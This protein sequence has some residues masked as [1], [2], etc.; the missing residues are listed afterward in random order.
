MQSPR[1]EEHSLTSVAGTQRV[2]E[3]P[4]PAL[5]DV[6]G[7]ATSTG[8]TEGSRRGWWSGGLQHGQICSFKKPVLATAV[9]SMP[10]RGSWV[11]TGSLGKSWCLLTDSPRLIHAFLCPLVNVD[12]HCIDMG[13]GDYLF[14][15]CLL[16]LISFV[17]SKVIEG[18]DSVLCFFLCCKSLT[19]EAQWIFRWKVSAE[20]HPGCHL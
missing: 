18:G 7:S 15:C 13:T 20:D 2:R 8:K 3:R 1:D 12:V 6:V 9:D 5:Q 10:C 16:W 17:N 19:P 4:R 11:D 14:F